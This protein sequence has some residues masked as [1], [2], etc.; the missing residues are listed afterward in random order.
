[1]SI[2]KESCALRCVQH[3]WVILISTCFTLKPTFLGTDT[4]NAADTIYLVFYT[5]YSTRGSYNYYF[6]SQIMLYTMESKVS[7]SFRLCVH[8]HGVDWFR[9][10]VNGMVPSITDDTYLYLSKGGNHCGM[11][12]W[13]SELVSFNL[14]GNLFS[15]ILQVNDYYR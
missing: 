3:V 4:E 1:M 7:C 15:T 10:A 13:L 6:S 2:F 12:D 8:I 14:K 5:C 11:L 9:A